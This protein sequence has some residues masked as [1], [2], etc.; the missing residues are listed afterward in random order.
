MSFR[1][2]QEESDLG[3]TDSSLKE[4]Q[5]ASGRP[6]TRIDA[7]LREAAVADHQGMFAEFICCFCCQS[8]SSSCTLL[9]LLM[10]F[11]MTP[12]SNI[13][14]ESKKLIELRLLLIPI[15]IESNDDDNITNTCVQ[16]VVFERTQVQG[17]LG[18]QQSVGM[19][20]YQT[21]S[22]DLVILS[23]GCKAMSLERMGEN[24]LDGQK[25]IVGQ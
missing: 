15:C 18:K 17:E 8:F 22:A 1:V 14:E 6:K 13:A 4:F 16:R 21:I 2:R 20:V 3:L 9:C 5:L 11:P 12:P 25:G 23:V 7:L 19:G 24:L 10:T